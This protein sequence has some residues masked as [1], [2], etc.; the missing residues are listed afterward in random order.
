MTPD[1]R[2]DLVGLVPFAAL[3]LCLRHKLTVDAVGPFLGGRIA[4]PALLSGTRFPLARQVF[5]TTLPAA[6]AYR[7]DTG[8][9]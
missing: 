2:A 1:D 4:L 6:R 5:C 7:K 9:A 3:G 8:R